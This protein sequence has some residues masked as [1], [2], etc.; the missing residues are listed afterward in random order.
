[1]FETSMSADRKTRNLLV[2]D[3]KLEK[4][5]MAGLTGKKFFYECKAGFSSSSQSFHV[6]FGS[7][8]QSNIRSASPFASI[9]TKMNIYQS[10]R[11]A[12]A[13]AEK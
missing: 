10:L 3:L 4:R 12:H 1:M 9:A 6:R 13:L 8:C 5:K 2:L 7:G 11:S